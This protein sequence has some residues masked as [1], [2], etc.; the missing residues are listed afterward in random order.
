MG[1]GVSL[2]ADMA[3]FRGRFKEGD[4]V[5]CLRSII[6]IERDVTL[7]EC[8]AVPVTHL[9]GLLEW[10]SDRNA[11]AGPHVLFIAWQALSL[12]APTMAGELVVITGASGLDRYL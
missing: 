4:R 10:W 1:D 11:A 3:Q 8:V 6:G 5:V 12:A 7:A 2:H 9:A